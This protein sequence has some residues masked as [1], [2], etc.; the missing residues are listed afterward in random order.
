MNQPAVI[1]TVKRYDQG[2]PEVNRPTERRC[3]ARSR[4]TRT[5]ITVSGLMALGAGG[6][7][8]AP[9]VTPPP[10]AH[11][12]GATEA[13]PS[14]AGAPSAAGPAAGPP[15]ATPPSPP[16]G[17]PPASAP[18][19]AYYPPPPAYPY[20]YPYPPAP[21]YPPP[22]PPPRAYRPPPWASP[23][24]AADREAW[25][26]QRPGW[27]AHDGLY[28]NLGVGIAYVHNTIRDAPERVEAN[29]TGIAFTAALGGAITRNV[30]LC[31][32][33]SLS[34]AETR[35]VDDQRGYDVDGASA[36]SSMVGGSVLYYFDD[37]NVFLGGTIGLTSFDVRN[38]FGS[39]TDSRA[40]FGGGLEVGKEWWV[41][42]NWG[43]G[44]V[45]RGFY[46]SAKDLSI[47]NAVWTNL[48][49][50]LFFSATYN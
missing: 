11:T 27:H 9:F 8:A 43:L 13:S 17:L 23:S 25:I 31:I 46:G 33:A 22:Y 20:S 39:Y 15:P 14:A 16:A 49:A 42:P 19:P 44:G 1:T 29:G 45:L 47:A 6:A 48:S 21:G 28:L 26:R 24:Y 2:S 38:R 4:R 40:R 35:F 5:L 32:R 50:G 37:S 12:G 3:L 10:A 34:N 36:E 41:S 18:P 7:Q 30:I